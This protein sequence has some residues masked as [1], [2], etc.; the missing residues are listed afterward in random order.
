MTWRTFELLLIAA[1][2]LDLVGIGLWY[3]CS[4]PGSQILGPALV[5][6]PA[7]GKR[8]ALTFDDGPLAPWT[9]QILDILKSRG[10]RATFFVCGRNA[11]RYPEIVQ[12]I[13]SEGHTLGNHTWSHPYLYFLS[14]RKIAE[15]IDKTQAAIRQA[16]GC[17]PRLFRPPYGARW[18]G[19][20]P[21]LRERK[22]ELIQW[23]LDP[24]DWRLDAESILA[25]VRMG[26]QP[27]AVILL[28][29]GRQAPGGYLRRLLNKDRPADGGELPAATFSATVEALPALIDEARREGFEFAPVEKFLQL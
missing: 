18:F 10:V 4:R 3:A 25:R 22:M 8:I 5:R 12:R 27:G 2:A 17:V 14:R 28:H 13:H 6:G 26:L 16:A 7:T 19:L 1:L 29:D 15:E 9:G 23:S 24:Q 11:E 20:Y 21:V